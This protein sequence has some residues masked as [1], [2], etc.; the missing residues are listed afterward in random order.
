[1][2]ARLLQWSSLERKLEMAR[3]LMESNKLPSHQSDN[4]LHQS[5]AIVSEIVDG[6]E[7]LGRDGLLQ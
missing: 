6:A 7:Q 3:Y 5:L 1:M 4:S 2:E